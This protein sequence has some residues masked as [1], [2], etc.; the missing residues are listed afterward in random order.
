MSKYKGIIDYLDS[1]DRVNVIVK[2]ASSV[3][4]RVS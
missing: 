4:Y 1:F 2:G 3:K